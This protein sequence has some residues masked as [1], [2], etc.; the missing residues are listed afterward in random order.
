MIKFLKSKKDSL[1]SFKDNLFFTKWVDL[2]KKNS[3]KEIYENYP[4][5]TDEEN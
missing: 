2:L 3:N 5:N 4:I 1:S